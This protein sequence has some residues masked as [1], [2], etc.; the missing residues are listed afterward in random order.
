MAMDVLRALSR[1]DVSASLLGLFEQINA[2]AKTFC[3]PA[4]AVALRSLTSALAPHIAAIVSEKPK[5]RADALVFA[6]LIADVIQ[7]RD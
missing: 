4:L 1:S 2:R 7:V 3:P 6:N 5:F